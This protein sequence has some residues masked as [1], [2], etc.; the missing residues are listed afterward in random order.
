[1]AEVPRLHKKREES[2]EEIRVATESVEKD[3]EFEIKQ[4]Q[5]I[6]LGM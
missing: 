4:I 6:R 3:I 1:L 5:T 2:A